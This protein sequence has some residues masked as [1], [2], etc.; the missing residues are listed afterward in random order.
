MRPV[1]DGDHRRLQQVRF[2]GRR[3]FAE[4]QRRPEIDRCLTYEQRQIVARPG[5]QQVEE[6][7]L[8]R[9]AG[10]DGDDVLVAPGW[11]EPGQGGN[12]IRT[13][14]ETNHRGRAAVEHA[15]VTHR[16]GRGS[17]ALVPDTSDEEYPFAGAGRQR[18]SGK[19]L[20]A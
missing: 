4:R 16:E 15:E 8:S 9:F 11:V 5:W 17:V 18:V 2:R 10:F 12:Y 19:A 1:G 3:R 6:E 13:G 20:R 14:V 7:R